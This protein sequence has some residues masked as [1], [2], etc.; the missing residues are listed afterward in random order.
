MAVVAP[1]PFRSQP[2][3]WGSVDAS[4]AEVDLTDSM[5]HMSYQYPPPPPAQNGAA[6]DLAPAAGYL[7]DYNSLPASSDMDARSSLDSNAQDLDKKLT[8]SMSTP[9]VRPGQPVPPPQQVGADVMGA[10][11]AS[12]A[13]ASEKRR[14]KLGYHR[15]S[16]ACGKSNS[17]TSSCSSVAN[18]PRCPQARSGLFAY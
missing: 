5:T 12:L 6:M 9:T 4:I 15:T 11:A 13:L 1:P 8:R 7:A 17:S 16:V 18:Y 3:L 2:E 14:N 10:D